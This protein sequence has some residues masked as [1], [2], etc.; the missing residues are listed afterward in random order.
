MIKITFDLNFISLAHLFQYIPRVYEARRQLC[1]RCKVPVAFA[2][3]IV[4]ATVAAASETAG[5][6]DRTSTAQAAGVQIETSTTTST[7]SSKAC[8]DG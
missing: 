2:R 4:D 3:G 8:A 1:P 7:S 6:D 5:A